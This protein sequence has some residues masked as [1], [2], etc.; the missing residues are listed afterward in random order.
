M[1]KIIKFTGIKF[2]ANKFTVEKKLILSLV[3]LVSKLNF[4]FYGKLICSELNTGEL[5]VD[6]LKNAYK[7][8]F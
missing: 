8:L 2:T 3:N 5:N 6:S 1:E 4:F 7:T